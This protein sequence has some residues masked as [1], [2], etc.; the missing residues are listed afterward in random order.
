LVFPCASLPVT[1]GLFS[2]DGTSSMYHP[3]KTV[4]EL[5]GCRVGDQTGQLC[6]LTFKVIIGHLLSIQG[7]PIQFVAFDV[8]SLLES[9]LVCA[10]TSGPEKGAD[11]GHA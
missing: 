5:A 11:D 4:D 10:E 8:P 1:F 9:V 2:G 3:P 6:S 7:L